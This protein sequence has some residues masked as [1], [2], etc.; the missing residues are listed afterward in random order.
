MRIC[1]SPI[2]VMTDRGKDHPASSVLHHAAGFA[3]GHHVALTS[4][5]SFAENL[6]SGP[7]PNDAEGQE[8]DRQDDDDRQENSADREPRSAEEG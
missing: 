3:L 4:A 8:Q 2:H 5:T 7:G 6:D 1:L